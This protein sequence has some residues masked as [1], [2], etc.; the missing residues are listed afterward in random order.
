MRILRGPVA[1]VG[2]IALCAL[3]SQVAGQVGDEGPSPAAAGASA[4][5]ATAV[6]SLCM[7]RRTG[8]DTVLGYRFRDIFMFGERATA[9]LESQVRDVPIRGCPLRPLLPGGKVNA[10]GVLDVLLQRDEG[11]LR[12]L[13]RRGVNVILLPE[14]RRAGEM[15]WLRVEAPNRYYRRI[16][17]AVRADTADITQEMIRDARIDTTALK[18]ACEREPGCN[19]P[20]RL[21]D[22]LRIASTWFKVTDSSAVGKLVLAHPMAD[23]GVVQPLIDSMAWGRLAALLEVYTNG[24][25]GCLPLYESDRGPFG[26][27]ARGVEPSYEVDAVELER[28]FY[29]RQGARVP[30]LYFFDLVQ[31]FNCPYLRDLWSAMVEQRAVLR[32]DLKA[33][34]V[35]GSDNVPELY[36]A[37]EGDR[38]RVRVVIAEQDVRQ[39]DRNLELLHE[40]RLPDVAA[41]RSATRVS[42]ADDIE[43]VVAEYGPRLQ[44]VAAIGYG[45]R[46]DDLSEDSFNPVKTKPAITSAFYLRYDGRRH[47]LRALQWMPGAFI[48]LYSL[49]AEETQ[50]TAGLAWAPPRLRHWVNIIYGW[51]DLK[52]PMV[53]MAL[54]PKIDFQAMLSRDK[55]GP[56]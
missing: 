36:A 31:R 53:G 13:R 2:V 46:A 34:A 33:L 51:H 6:T 29:L 24:P 18:E 30:V 41:Y 35:I 56:Q 39:R 50:F 38:I 44:I 26:L 11:V 27:A 14:L 45:S 12:H 23:T 52:V 55:P 49:G 1:L 22:S 15:T 47:A 25:Y 28:N 16:E 21:N 19:W 3:P 43:F 5:Q 17:P 4:G 42:I 7:D 8:I 20:Q 54:S 37:R 32:L 10:L 40:Y 9:A 48:G